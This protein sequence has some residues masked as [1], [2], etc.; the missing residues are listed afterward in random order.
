MRRALQSFSSKE[1]RQEH[2]GG[3]SRKR[4]GEKLVYGTINQHY[5]IFAANE[6][7]AEIIPIPLK[8]YRNPFFE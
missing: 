5:K 8:N 6:F 7:H 2:L 4:E 1:D 3:T